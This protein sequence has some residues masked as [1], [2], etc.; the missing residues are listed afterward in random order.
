MDINLS[1]Y[2]ALAGDY[3]GSLAAI[4]ISSVITAI[5]VLILSL[6]LLFVLKKFVLVKRKHVVLKVFSIAYFILI[7][8]IC[9]FFA[10][11]WQFLNKLGNNIAENI[12]K[13]TKIVDNAVK[14]NMAAVVNTFYLDKSENLTGKIP[15]SVNNLID[16]L[17]DSLYSNYLEINRVESPNKQSDM[18]DKAITLYIDVTK[19]KGLSFLIKEALAHIITKELKL[20]KETT[21]EIM[22]TK[23]GKLLDDGILTKILDSKIEGFFGSMKK[24]V[25]VTLCIIL[26]LPAIEIGIAFWFF[27]KDKKIAEAAGNSDLTGKTVV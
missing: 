19:S 5:V 8:I 2:A 14:S 15:V 10:F 20:E 3:A 22:D 6:V 26:L 11:K 17:G 27:Q 1:D 9:A 23:L 16:I 24:S 13:D 18:M 4:T 21:K 25:L 12:T 7:P